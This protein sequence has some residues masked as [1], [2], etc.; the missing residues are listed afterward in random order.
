MPAKLSLAAALVIILGGGLWLF[1]GQVAVKS[2]ANG[3][4]VNPPGNTI[5]SSLVNGTVER[6][7]PSLGTRVSQGQLIT[8]I[9]NV[10]GDLIKVFS[11]IT[12]H[13]VSLSTSVHSTVRVGESLLTLA[14]DTDPMVA[15]LFVSAGSVSAITPGMPVEVAVDTLNVGET[16]VL[17]GVV[18]SVS[19]LPVTDERLALIL[20]D[21]V[22]IKDLTAS[23][24]VHEVIVR[25]VSDPTKPLGLSWSG[26]GPEPGVI[27]SSGALVAGQ[28]VLREQSPWQALLGI[29]NTTPADPA[30]LPAP[31]PT[32]A[33]SLPI[34]ANLVVGKKVTELEVA[35]TPRQ[36][37]TGLMFRNNLPR[38]R[39]MIFAFD[40]A[41]PVSFWMRDTLIPLDI[42]Y[43]RNGVVVDV[44]A[45]VPPC[46]T[47]PCPAYPS[48]SKVDA[49][50]ELADGRAAELGIK[51]GSKIVVN[52][53]K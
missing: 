40:S 15:L 46:E 30:S 17:L 6:S 31:G 8:D 24:P 38:N 11:P 12:G 26:P 3:V 19:P 21:D 25:F 18:D 37:E 51:T 50:I 52:Y 10:Q 43:V 7:M 35:R 5:V 13:V 23:G 41:I 27:I 44:E 29:D 14:P 1:G 45:S 49:V 34:G 47:D 32:A 22:Y 9:R 16:G 36:Q 39:G 53:L 20:D 2:G 48:P 28:F 33:Q 42:I 4:I